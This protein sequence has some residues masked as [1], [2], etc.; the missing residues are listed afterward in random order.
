LTDT[1]P[2]QPL[3]KITLD[4]ALTRAYAS[5]ADYQ[6]ALAQVRAATLTRKAAAAGYYPSVAAAVDYGDIGV[7]PANS[8]GTLD[9]TAAVNIPVFQ[10]N[11][12]HGEI[13]KA[14]SALRQSR[15]LLENL[16]AQIDQDVRNA[17]LDLQSAAEQVEVAQ[18]TLDLA[19]QT[20]LQARDRFTAGVTDNIEVVQAQQSVASAN[21]T[22]IASLY[23]YNVSKVELGRAT[24]H[25]EASVEQI[26]SGR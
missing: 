10:G 19:N 15:E 22:L 13:L 9:A 8:H 18:S 21:E 12:V 20:L 11:R 5:R 4:E 16:R 24:G 26:L 2:Y 25:A 7:N 17:L 23:A 14:E 3:P 6:S 1:T